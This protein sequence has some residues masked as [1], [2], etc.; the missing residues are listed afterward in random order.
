MLEQMLQTNQISQVWTNDQILNSLCYCFSGTVGNER[1]APGVMIR[2][3][4]SFFSNDS[5]SAT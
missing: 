2:L 5:V 3:S 4:A 1:S